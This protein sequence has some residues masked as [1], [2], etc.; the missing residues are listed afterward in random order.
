MC[1]CVCVCERERER[2]STLS[3]S[4]CVSFPSYCNFLS[5]SHF[6]KTQLAHVVILVSKYF[7]CQVRDLLDFNK[8]NA[9]MWQTQLGPVSLRDILVIYMYVCV[10]VYARHF[11]YICVYLQVHSNLPSPRPVRLTVTLPCLCDMC[12]CLSVSL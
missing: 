9:G 10:C 4:R 6:I 11:G 7:E 1:E 2:E 3:V 12:V 8:L 5:I